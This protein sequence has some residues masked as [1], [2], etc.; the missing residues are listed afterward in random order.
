MIWRRDFYVH[1]DYYIKW[2]KKNVKEDFQV[3]VI[4]DDD[5][6]EIEVTHQNEITK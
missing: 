1:K 2:I 3:K 6:E 5:N 4:E